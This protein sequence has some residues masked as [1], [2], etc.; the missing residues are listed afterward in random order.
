MPAQRELRF[1][2]LF[3]THFDALLAYARRRSA[4]LSD[5]EDVAAETFTTAWRRLDD[6]PEC[7]DGELPWLY[8]VARRVLANQRRSA[9]RRERLVDRLRSALTPGRLPVP[10]DVV[11]ALSLLSAADQEVLR[12]AAWEQLSHRE[13]AITLGISSNAAGIRLHRARRRLKHVMKGSATSRTS[14]EWKGSVSSAREE[15]R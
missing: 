9:V 7:A 1:A 12:L 6:L 10:H 8:G 4:Q 3:D 13:I 5:A 2:A 14:P 11:D 15:N